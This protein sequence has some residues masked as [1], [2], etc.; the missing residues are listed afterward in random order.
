MP[1]ARVAG[2][3]EDAQ[4]EKI[5]QSDRAYEEVK[6]LIISLRLPPGAVIEETRLRQDVGVGRT[7]LREAL[8]RLA[9]LGLVVVAPHRGFF[10]TE[11]S[12]TDLQHLTE[13]RL[14]LE[15]AAARLA[16]ER[17]GPSVVAE[18]RAILDDTAAAIDAHDLSKLIAIDLAFHSL[19]ARASLNRYLEDALHRHYLMMLRFWYLSFERAGHLPDVMRE[20]LHIVSAIE[21]RDGVNAETAMR[22]HVVEFRNKVRNLL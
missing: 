10:V 4:S 18:L 13:L 14:L 11:I 9:D 21:Q 20:H 19:I 1:V 22:F 2:I 15:G 16:A 8:Y 3:D 17:A 6:Q 12:A 5:K 7:P